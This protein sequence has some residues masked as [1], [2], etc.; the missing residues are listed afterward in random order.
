MNLEIEQYYDIL[1]SSKLFYNLDLEAILHIVKCLEGYI[2]EYIA[3]S[4]ILSYGSRTEYAGVVLS[5]KL[6]LVIP[7]SDGSETNMGNIMES[8]FFACANSCIVGQKYLASAIA[9]K[10]SKI[11]F[12]KFSNLFKPYARRCTFASMMTAN[13]LRQIAEESVIQEKRIRVMSQKSIRAKVIS[14]IEEFSEDGMCGKRTMNNQELA[15]FL[16]IDRSALSRE[17][18]RMKYEG[19]I[20]WDKCKCKLLI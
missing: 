1:R 14:Y 15:N 8:G 11:L 17:I 12:L 5:G 6:S 2:R 3:G 7:E 20:E 18:S 13:L 10:D 4:I 16:G 19:I 9:K